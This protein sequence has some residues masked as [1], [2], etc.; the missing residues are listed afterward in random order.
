MSDPRAT[1][2]LMSSD[3]FRWAALVLVTALITLLFFGMIRGFLISLIMAAIVAEMSRPLFRRVCDLV[4]GRRN[5]A[6]AITLTL[7]IVLVI[8]PVFL[9]GTVAAEQ[10]LSLP[11]TVVRVF[12]NLAEQSQTWDVPDW[13]PF[14]EDMGHFGP[15]V[16]SKISDLVSAVARYMVGTMSA[17][18][19]GTALLFL[20][21]FI[22]IYALFFFLKME[23]PVMQQILRFTSL[24]PDTQHKLADR[25]ISV[26]R[27]TIK[28]V[29]VIGIVQGLLGGIG[30]WVAG[31]E[32][33][34]FWGVVMGIVSI[35]PGVGPSLVLAI[36]V[37]YLFAVGNMAAAIGLALWAGLV[38]TTID[39]ILR[40][41]L[42]GRDTQ[43]HD[44]LILVSTFGGLG[45][46]GAVG[47]V[48]GPVVAGLFVTIWT[49]LAEAVVANSPEPE[50]ETAVGSDSD[51]V[52]SA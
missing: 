11:R 28:G 41:I 52:E 16:V 49:T 6:S 22:F 27:A 50:A 13:L 36:G 3:T 7:I 8:A 38:V 14:D 32:G 51:A 2:P 47:L 39:N 26:S 30:F 29:L 5:V 37:L 45:M 35:I 33:A 42:V 21:T 34:T 23:V 18:T 17:V 1:P 31:I 19:R 46:F 48:L 20:D 12:N 9:I 40:P 10:A 4:K 43:M 25:A 24:A 44:I 15:E